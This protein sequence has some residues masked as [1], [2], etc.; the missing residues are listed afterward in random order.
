MFHIKR[1]LYPTDFSSYSTQ[2]YFHAVALAETHRAALT[3]L[4][5]FNP[6]ADV[7]PDRAY[8]REQLE[9]IRPANPN[10]PVEHVFL[11]GNPADVI[12][13][14]ASE[15]GV[16]MVV[17]GTHGRTAQ[18]RLLMGSVAEQT[19]RTAPCSVLVVKLPKRPVQD[20]KP[21]VELVGKPS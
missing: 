7:R 21:D 10:I 5:V 15:A 1:I 9:Q 18:E 6:G 2:A 12:P 17:M 16:D 4:Y 13:N 19:L 11:E 3:I 8:W 14:Y 20:V